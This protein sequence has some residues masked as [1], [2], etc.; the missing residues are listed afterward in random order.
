MS[1]PFADN[2]GSL[3]AIPSASQRMNQ[4]VAMIR[5]YMR[6]QPE[7]N[8]LIAGQETND[9]AIAWAIVDIFDDWNSTPPFLTPCGL[10]NIPSISIMRDGITARILESAAMLQMRNHLSFSDGG[11]SQSVSDKGPAYINFAQYLSQRYEQKKGAFKASQ[12]IE[13]AMDGH[14]IHSEYFLINAAYVQW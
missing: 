4:L 2:G 6:D 11:L 5:S 3:T 9:R 1:F 7:L 8:R 13:M 10:S 12:N 14:G